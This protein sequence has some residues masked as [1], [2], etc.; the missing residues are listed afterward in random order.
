MWIAERKLVLNK[1]G[2]KRFFAFR[3]NRFEPSS[4]VTIERGSPALSALGVV[5]DSDAPG[6]AVSVMRNALPRRKLLM[7]ECD[8]R[9]CANLALD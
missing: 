5:H 7:R 3:R 2:V 4:F 1:A 6:V 8:Q 9:E